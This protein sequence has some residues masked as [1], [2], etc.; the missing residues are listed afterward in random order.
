MKTRIFTSLCLLFFGI[1]VFAQNSI[2]DEERK[3]AIQYMNESTDMLMKTVKGLS[4]EQLAYKPN[5]DV[6]SV[7]ECLKHLA[8]SEANIWAGFMEAGLAKEADPSRRSEIQMTDDMIMGFIVNREQKVKTFPPFEP[9]NKAEDFK[10]V[11][12]EFK[13]LRA[14][15]VK[16]MKKTDADLRNHYADTPFGVIDC[17]QAVLFISGHVQRH[18]YQMKEVMAS[19]GF[20]Q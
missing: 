3:K 7:E 5:A 11:M 20:P 15:H 14:E 2:T 16:W 8:I 6:W 9:E 12:K 4:P 18:T 10:T 19:E 1:T 13:S 17:Y